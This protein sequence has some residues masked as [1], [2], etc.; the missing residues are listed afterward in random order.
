MRPDMSKIL[1][2]RPRY[3]HAARYPRALVANRT[4][5]DEGGPT[6]ERMGGFYA[7]K[8]FD[9]HLGP[10]R[11]FLTSRI[12]R[13]WSK[14]KSEICAQLRVTS[15]VQRHVMQH[16]RDYVW[17]RTWI[18]EDG[19]IWG[20]DRYGA[21]SRPV[22]WSRP[23]FFVHPRSGLLL[24]MPRAKP[25]RAPASSASPHVRT[26]VEDRLEHRRVD[27]VWF[28]VELDELPPN[29]DD[30]WKLGLPVWDVVARRRVRRRMTTFGDPHP[31]AK[32]WARGLYARAMRQLSKREI[33]RAS[34][35]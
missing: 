7:E 15:T 28:E 8:T 9:D 22:V 35:A 19:E 20:A 3:A 23:G 16:V 24:P 6:K 4:R 10:L 5:D 31:M 11:R 1:I 33:R 17:E 12:G 26:I 32:L 14:V 2:E 25:K 29:P 13:P 21:P 30:A 34:A 18:D 27:G